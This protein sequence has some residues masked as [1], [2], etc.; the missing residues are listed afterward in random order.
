MNYCFFNRK[1]CHF[2]ILVLFVV[3]SNDV[4]SSA[5]A[6]FLYF[7]LSQIEKIKKAIDEKKPEIQPFNKELKEF[8]DIM[9]KREP[10]SVTF[11]PTKAIIGPKNGSGCP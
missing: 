4:Y 6:K 2:L 7:D 11:T 1:I 10:W 3:I 5:K 8:A 9:L